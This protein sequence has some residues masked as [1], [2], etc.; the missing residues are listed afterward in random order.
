MWVAP[1]PSC[2]LFS[3]GGAT[4]HQPE[5]LERGSLA[6]RPSEDALAERPLAASTAGN[7]SSRTHVLSRPFPAF[8]PCQR[9]AGGPW[10]PP[11]EARG[12]T[13][14]NILPRWT[15]CSLWRSN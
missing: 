9:T 15:N 13:I 12:E 4:N 5:H 10:H 14:L 8:A 2:L 3:P 6:R 11:A 7:G 1:S